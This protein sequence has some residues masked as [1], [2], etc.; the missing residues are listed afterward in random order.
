[1]P[2]HNDFNEIYLELTNGY[3]W[4]ESWWSAG[5]D[6]RYLRHRQN[7]GQFSLYWIIV[8]LLL[9]VIGVIFWFF[10]GPRD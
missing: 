3:E 10:A 7:V 1:L 9:P 4:N 6:R 2:G 8:I 5:F